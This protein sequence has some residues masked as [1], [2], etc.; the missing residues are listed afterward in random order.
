VIREFGA[1]PVD[2]Q[3]QSVQDYVSELTDEMGFD[4]ILDTVG[5]DVLEASFGAVKRY[6]GKVVSVS[7]WGAHSLASL[8]FRGASYSGIFSLYPLISGVGRERQGRILADVAMLVST[9]KLRQLVSED[10]FSLDTV[11]DAYHRMESGNIDGKVVISIATE[12]HHQ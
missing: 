12:D 10:E 4:M 1:W 6:T 11:E 7:G 5:G 8:S 3:S 9:G 2:F